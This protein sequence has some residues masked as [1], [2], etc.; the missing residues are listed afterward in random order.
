MSLFLTNNLDLPAGTVVALHATGS[1]LS[2]TWQSTRGLHIIRSEVPAQ[3]C[4]REQ[5]AS[6]L[7]EAVQ[8]FKLAIA[9]EILDE[10]LALQSRIGPIS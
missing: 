5:C 6:E 8:A 7:S 4:R 3:W 9:Q 2:F 1:L 10:E